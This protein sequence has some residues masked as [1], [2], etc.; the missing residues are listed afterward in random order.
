MTKSLDGIIGSIHSDIVESNENMI[1]NAELREYIEKDIKSILK[2]LNK[3]KENLAD[4][5]KEND[6]I[7]W[8][9]SKK[10]EKKSS[11]IKDWYRYSKAIYTEL[12]DKYDSTNLIGTFTTDDLYLPEVAT[13]LGNW[14]LYNHLRYFGKAIDFVPTIIVINSYSTGLVQDYSRHIYNTLRKGGCNTNSILEGKHYLTYPFRVPDTYPARYSEPHELQT[15]LSDRGFNFIHTSFK[16]DDEYKK[17]VTHL[18]GLTLDYFN[19]WFPIIISSTS[20][21]SLPN[22][23]GVVKA[24]VVEK[25]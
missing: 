10:I 9:W 2:R 18:R 8:N 12:L 13:I 17:L 5:A 23:K 6:A 11:P 16:T 3:G 25:S 1:E 21:G 4:I 19:R 14:A 15:L 24:D 20:F 7:N 22:I